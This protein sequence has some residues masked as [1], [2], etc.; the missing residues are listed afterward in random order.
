MSEKLELAL[1]VLD[2]LAEC[3]FSHE[4]YYHLMV[5][6]LTTDAVHAARHTNPEDLKILANFAEDVRILQKWDKEK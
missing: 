2:D 5:C 1:E 4:E 3:S 6:N